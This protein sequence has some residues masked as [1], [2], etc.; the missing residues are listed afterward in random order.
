M[1]HNTVSI[2]KY[3]LANEKPGTGNPSTSSIQL[4]A[5]QIKEAINVKAGVMDA[6]VT[7]FS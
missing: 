4:K 3:K 6:D 2:K 5:K 1:N 7:S